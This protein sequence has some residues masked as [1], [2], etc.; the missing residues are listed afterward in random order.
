MVFLRAQVAYWLLA[1]TDGHAK[2]FSVSLGPAGR[3]AL[4]PLYDVMS[5][6]PNLDAR[7]VPA[8]QDATGHGCR[9]QPQAAYR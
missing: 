9:R 2:N 7:E 8:E 6:Q 3:F 1:A 5:L 4:T